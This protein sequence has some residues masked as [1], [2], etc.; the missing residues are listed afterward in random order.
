M[1]RI[2]ELRLHAPSYP[3]LLESSDVDGGSSVA[4]LTYLRRILDALDHP[5][6]VHMILHYLLAMQEAQTKKPQTPMSPILARRRSSLILMTEPA[7]EDDRMNPSLFNL[8]DLVLSSVA[9]TN[10]QTV[11]SALKLV[12][13]ILSK[14]HNYAV[15]TLVKTVEIPTKEPQ[16]THGAL[17]AEVAAYLALA[18]DMGG[19]SG[20][21]EAYE[22]HLKDVQSALE[23]HQC[24]RQ[25]LLRESAGSVPDYF[26]QSRPGPVQQHEILHQDLLLSRLAD[27]LSTFLTNSVETNLALTEAF[28]TL[29]VCA[30]VKLESWLALDPVYY[31]FDDQQALEEQSE[32]LHRIF[33]ARREP[34]WQSD[35]APVLLRLITSLSEQLSALRTQIPDLEAHITSRKQAF[36]V[37]EEITEAMRATPQIRAS[38]PQTETPSG[39]WTPQIPRHVLESSTPASSRSMSPSARGRAGQDSLRAATG[40]PAA[41]RSL[42]ASPAPSSSRGRSV[43]AGDSGRSIDDAL[44]A[45]VV[46]NMALV[47][48][49][50]GVKKKVRF[51]R[52]A[53]GS[54]TVEYIQGKDK[55]G[56]RDQQ[57][58]ASDD[59]QGPDGDKEMNEKAVASVKEVS[60]SHVLTNA[61]ILQE[62]VLELVA[63][64]QVRA[65]LFGEVKFA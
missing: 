5:E 39:S 61:V 28:S 36:R 51:T 47:T 1:P 50:E 41:K 53:D 23:S 44:L 32:M 20:L 63:L 55:G 64:L 13:V 65:S 37:H 49:A 33:L 59:V 2:R 4:V 45:D 62:F 58:T 43:A 46:G 31:Q 54:T 9:S 3:S 27:L 60:L 17:N 19:E 34:S 6:L 7:D 42:G 40:S 29:G 11:I 57:K 15:G 8:V 16:R 18:E 38:R 52:F 26:S 22:G 25:L 21:D 10:P 14:N 24:S 56:S 30:Q 12:S 48:E 35:R